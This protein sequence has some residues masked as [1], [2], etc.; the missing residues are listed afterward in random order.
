[1]KCMKCNVETSN[2]KFCSSSC[3]AS[4]NNIGVRRHGASPGFCVVC[5]GPKKHSSSTFCSNKCQAQYL[6]K[7]KCDEIKRNGFASDKRYL[8]KFIKEIKGW[9][10][11][12]CKCSEWNGEQAPL[13]LHHINEDKFD[14]RIENGMMLCPNCHAIIHKHSKKL[15]GS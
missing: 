8:K 1:M 12:I 7:I 15:L 2:R 6:W 10:C 9:K 11:E 3:S 4:Y 14:N 5:D 13:E